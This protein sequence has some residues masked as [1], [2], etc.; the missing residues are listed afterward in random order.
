MLPTG[1]NPPNRSRT[2]HTHNKETGMELRTIFQNTIYWKN[3]FL[4]LAGLVTFATFAAYPVGS[5]PLPPVLR[6]QAK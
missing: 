3:V 4:L 1:G 6:S 5:P 2:S